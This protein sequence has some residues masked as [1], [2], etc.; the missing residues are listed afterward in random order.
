M[1]RPDH[2][3]FNPET[4]ELLRGVLEG[5][6]QAMSPQQR[7]ITSKS[8]VA[9]RILRIAAQ[10]ETDPIRL[11][12]RALSGLFPASYEKAPPAPSVLEANVSHKKEA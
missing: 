12:E 10:G 7:A 11:R 2:W 5:T 4:S 1:K 6:W 9:L 8:E 3:V